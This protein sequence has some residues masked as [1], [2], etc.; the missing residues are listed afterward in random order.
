MNSPKHGMAGDIKRIGKYDVVEV[1]GRGGMGVVY[2]GVDKLLGREVAIK[3]LTEGVADDPEMLARFYEEGRK[4]A[5][6]KHPNIVTV[7]DLGEENKLPYI[8]MERVEGDPLDRII[9]SDESI[10][11]LDRLRIIEEVCEALGYAHRNNVIHRDVKPANVFVQPDGRAKLLDFG[12]ARLERRSQE[13][14][15]TRA[16][17]II[18]TIPYM[19]PERL[20]DHSI[21]SRSDIFSAGVLLF[22][23]ISRQLPFT[24]EDFVLMQKIINEPHPQLSSL[25]SVCPA[26][27]DAIVDRALAKSADDRYQTAEEM[28]SDLSNVIAELKEEQVRDMLPEAR[29]LV[30]A[31]EWLKARTVLQ[32]LLKI[33]SRN[34][35]ARSL[36]SEIHLRMVQQQREV[37]IEQFRQQAEDALSRREFER[38]LSVL[39]DGLSADPSSDALLQLRARVQNELA[40]RKQIE[41]FLTQAEV[42]RRR[43]DYKAAI[44]SAQEALKV[45]NTDSKLI[46]LCK[47]LA[48]QAEKA[49]KKVKAK[50]LV[51]AARKHLSVQ[52]YVQALELLH[53]A[54]S[55]DPSDPDA[56]LLFNDAT[57]GFE[58]MRRKELA[59]RLEEQL[60]TASNLD[61]LREAAKSIQESIS[62]SPDDS[63]LY[64]LSALVDRRIKDQESLQLVENAIQACRDFRAREALEVVRT[65]RQ[66][67]PSDERLLTL[68]RRLVER[69]QQQAVDERRIDYLSRA[70][71]ALRNSDF[72]NAIS[73]LKECQANHI[74]NDEVSALLEFAKKEEQDKVYQDALKAKLDRAQTCIDNDQLETAI[75]FLSAELKQAGDPALRVLLEDATAARKAMRDQILA[76]LAVANKLVNESSP[77]DAIQYLRSQR[78]P[79][80]KHVDVKAAIAVLENQL[81]SESF[82]TIGKAY[83]LMESDL[84]TAD[85]LFKSVESGAADMVETKT[86][87]QAFRTRQGEVADRVIAETIVHCTNVTNARERVD[88][89]ALAQ[90]VSVVWD[91]ASSESQAAW[92]SVQNRKGLKGVFKKFRS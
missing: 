34:T 2:R 65:A 50:E 17:H 39:N 9:N 20:R 13:L 91:W 12:I 90:H 77:R 63:G 45:D 74:S 1:L 53:A 59:A 84:R 37:R 24:G 42:A 28:A 44:V 23:L 57:A 46:V 86:F 76:A 54:E 26:G 92:L 35:E 64:R 36:L 79:I 68:E 38:C 51:D 29:R 80:S 27:L 85:A 73:I 67:L 88:A 61:Q 49:E 21:D 7:Y 75:K 52:N 48:L 89:E 40:K 43:G 8:V 56:Q 31:R 6:L 25:C 87:S 16:G 11:M 78:D 62:S 14:T 10:P 3:T 81:N 47:S 19:A 58:R 33:Q 55:L 83:A 70:R 69:L 15:L 5:R 72:A 82:L 18:G 22:Q 41:E 60:S 30:E 71:E 66:R 4:T 32:Q